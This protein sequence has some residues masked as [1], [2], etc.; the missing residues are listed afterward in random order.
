MRCAVGLPNV[1]EYGD[2]RLIRDLGIEAE[3]AGWDGFFVWDHLLYRGANDPVANPWISLAAVAE[4]TERIRL[5]VMVAA[6]ARRRPWNVARE[7]AALDVL[8]EGRMIFGAGLGSLREEYERFGEDPDERIRA[9]KLDEALE[10]V[11]GLWKGEPLAFRGRHYEIESGSFLPTPQQPRVPVWIAGRWPH[12]RPMR[13]AS[14][15]DGVFATHEE[16]AAP[17]TMT[18]DQLSEIV[19]YVL[20]HRDAPGPFDVVIEGVTHG[21]D[22]SRDAQAVTGYAEAGLTWWVEK[23]GWFRGTPEEMRTRIKKGPP[24][25]K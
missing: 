13:R 6:L 14:R 18:V 7:V 9:E 17:E 1:K 22:P 19:A 24:I 8:S 16:V 11:T 20:R 21:S 23:L 10:I 12:R 25:P 5:G 2:P 3:D 4:R 15:W